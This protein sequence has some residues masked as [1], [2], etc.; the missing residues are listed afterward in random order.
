VATGLLMTAAGTPMLFMGQEFLEDKLWSDD[1]QLTDREIWWEGVEGAD[2]AMVDFHRYVRELIR[3]RRRH[4]ALR[5]DPMTVHPL[6]LDQRV[7]A[8]HRWVPGTGRDVVVVASFAE[9]TFS[10]DYEL[11]FPR[12]G[13]WR[14][15]LNSDY[16]DNFPNPAV[17]GNGGGITAAGPPRHDLPA[18]ARITIPANGLLVFATDPGDPVAP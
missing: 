5:A 3:L 13:F 1:V 12:P 8:F 7:L 16:F 2:R 15:E 11:G 18:S 14:E 6:A 10:G 9:S 4:P 17:Q